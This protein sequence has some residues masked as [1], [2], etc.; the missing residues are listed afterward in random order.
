MFKSMGKKLIAISC[1]D[2][3]SFVRG[4]PP[5]TIFF[6]GGGG[7]GGREGGLDGM[8]RGSKFH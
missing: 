7:G 8:E 1:A 2:P 5:L 4:G 3:E 6:L